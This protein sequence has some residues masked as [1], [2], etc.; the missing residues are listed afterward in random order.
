MLR[1]SKNHN[2]TP[3][4]RNSI[5]INYIIINQKLMSSELY[6]GNELELSLLTSTL[7][8]VLEGSCGV[9]S[10]CGVAGSG[11]TAVV[12]RLLHK[13]KSQGTLEHYSN[14][15]GSDITADMFVV[16]TEPNS[17]LLDPNKYNIVW[18]DDM[19]RM[20]DNKL[21]AIREFCRS[22]AETYTS[23]VLTI[24][25]YTTGSSNMASSLIPILQDI[26]S[27]MEKNGVN[28]TSI[29][30]KPLKLA[31]VASLV[32]RIYN[33]NNFESNFANR[34][35]RITGGNQLF[36][37][38]LLEYMED[39]QIISKND[40]NVYTAT[41][42][43]DTI[44]TSVDIARNRVSMLTQ[45]QYESSNT[46]SIELK[47][48][49]NILLNHDIMDAETKRRFVS[50][51]KKIARSDNDADSR[52]LAESTLK[53]FSDNTDENNSY[54]T[55]KADIRIPLKTLLKEYRMT[56][57]IDA[58]EHIMSTLPSSQKAEYIDAL[59]CKCEALLFLGLYNQAADIANNIISM[60]TQENLTEAIMQGYYLKGM[61]I[62]Y[63]YK[64]EACDNCFAT[65]SQIAESLGKYEEAAIYLCRRS[66]FMM[67]IPNHEKMQY[68]IDKVLEMGKKYPIGRAS[69]EVQLSIIQCKFSKNESLDD[70]TKVY[71]AV[72]Y[73]ESIHDVRFEAR[74]YN[75]IAL[76]EQ[77]NFEIDAAEK[78]FQTALNLY[79]SINDNVGLVSVFNNIAQLHFD[80]GNY[81][82]AIEYY[83]KSASIA[84]RLT[85]LSPIAFS[86]S[87]I[88]SSYI[89]LGDLTKAEE[90]IEKCIKVAY[91][92]GRDTVVAGAYS[93]MA[94]LQMHKTN[95]QKSM[96]YYTKV[97]E[98]DRRLN[99][100]QN[101]T[102]DLTNIA[103]LYSSMHEVEKGIKYIQEIEQQPN[104]NDSIKAVIYNT[105]GNLYAELP[106]SIKALKYYNE[107]L[108]IN[109]N[110]GDNV[111]ASLNLYNISL[112]YTNTGKHDIAEQTIEKAVEIDRTTFD[113]LQL[114]THLMRL[115]EC[116]VNVGK[117]EEG[118][119]AYL[120]AV[121]I[122]KRM[123]LMM[124]AASA[125]RFCADVSR[126]SNQ[127]ST[128]HKNIE[129]ALN[130]YK[131]LGNFKEQA[132]TY[133]MMAELAIS[134]NNIDG[135][136]S[137]AEKSL[138]MF[139][140][141]NIEKDFTYAHILQ[142]LAGAYR[143]HGE[144]NMTIDCY[145]RLTN[146]YH[147]TD[148]NL[149]VEN[150]LLEASMLVECKNTK[151]AQKVYDSINDII[152]NVTDR[153]LKASALNEIGTFYCDTDRINL[154]IQTKHR[155]IEEIGDDISSVDTKAHIYLSSADA[156]YDAGMFDM[157]IVE[158]KE[159]YQIYANYDFKEKAAYVCNN[160][161]YTYDTIAKCEKAIKYYM[162]AFK[163]YQEKNNTSGMYN[164]INNVALMFE[165]IGN[166][167]EALKFYKKAI[168]FVN[169]KDYPIEY[170][171]SLFNIGRCIAATYNDPFEISRIVSK[172]SCV[173]FEENYFDNAVSCQETLALFLAQHGASG[174]T[175]DVQ[176]NELI[177]LLD[178]ADS[179]DEK[180]NALISLAAV[181]FFKGDYEIAI[182]N[183][184]K[185]VKI[186]TD[187]DS[188]VE[189]ARCH[190]NMALKMCFNP[191]KFDIEIPVKGVM[192]KISDFSM[193]C[194]DFAAKLANKEND[195]TL[196]S[197]VLDARA[198]LKNELGNKEGAFLDIT[199][200][201]NTSGDVEFQM[202][203]GI[204]KGI[205]TYEQQEYDKALDIFV[206]VANT[207]EKNDLFDTLYLAKGW[208][209]LIMFKNGKTKEAMDI[210]RNTDTDYYYIYGGITDLMSFV[211]QNI[212]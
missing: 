107:A 88:G 13:M 22:I 175:L 191:K 146:L 92:T 70:I 188:W 177:K 43:P 167:S 48:L 72:K 36:L 116:K 51:L 158:Y 55:D 17:S 53:K 67:E 57:V 14:I 142:I 119:N 61:A 78:H 18:F 105:Y 110:R 37:R 16:V 6:E 176:K 90:Y 7:E 19:Q 35:Y 163:L 129:E 150:A 89:Y 102:S 10:I 125:L 162:M 30:T 81:N 181:C 149:Y 9:V 196:L 108:A 210:I 25:S 171:G 3:C 183:F 180:V 38:L 65:A 141:Y 109:T 144:P 79:S 56:E 94:D 185:A 63:L 169:E 5:N 62:G 209:S 152:P 165:R 136:I 49:C 157:A 11:K 40:H 93:S 153:K 66:L 33:V 166:M 74:L 32:S 172:A 41:G 164:N 205:W 96:E 126:I 133:G 76:Y 100:M 29:E 39:T 130:I 77:N 161:G 189:I 42:I 139:D 34:L 184:Y 151:A 113:Q 122:Y 124:E 159:A 112:L 23:G 60:A 192:R 15:A 47:K 127:M 132:I 211:S 143:A 101:V 44:N 21:K 73:F 156:L 97:L 201:I 117:L 12:L 137:V 115:G 91:Q 186:R 59:C 160:I 204:R 154:G 179:A 190:Y 118:H 46:N 103:S 197:E 27:T 50:L 174:S 104:N 20:S 193:E 182:D 99:D 206:D 168:E 4:F 195:K 138:K 95:Y 135:A 80:I 178:E 87:G 187:Q 203:L 69:S 71:E 194:L 45:S 82:L 120:E 200:A 207:S 28:T 202:S 2:F 98:I 173:Y 212:N 85:I 68:C 52:Q 83:G 170:A 147:D 208:Q 84:E 54:S 111:N 114:A 8:N 26:T 24:L 145:H 86:Y 155:A 1:L 128:A 131:E 31:D 121:S 106:D 148:P 198:T 140:T 134:E 123:N 75:S 64:Y 58:A 199:D